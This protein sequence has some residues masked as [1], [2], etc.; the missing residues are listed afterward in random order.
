MIILLEIINRKTIQTAKTNYFIYIK[1][2]IFHI[3]LD[4]PIMGIFFT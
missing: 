4:L 2:R 3:L 1:L